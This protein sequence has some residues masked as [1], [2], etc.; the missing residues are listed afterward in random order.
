MVLTVC[1][2]EK[3]GCRSCMADAVDKLYNNWGEDP[4]G[5]V[6]C[7]LTGTWCVTGGGIA[8]LIKK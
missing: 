5:T 6:I 2:Y 1:K 7:W 4:I 3:L 8:C